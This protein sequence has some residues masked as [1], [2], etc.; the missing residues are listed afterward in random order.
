M[1]AQFLISRTHRSQLGKETNRT[2]PKTSLHGGGTM[3]ARHLQPHQEVAVRIALHRFFTHY[4]CPCPDL[5]E[6]RADCEAVAVVAVLTAD[7]ESRTEPLMS[8]MLS[9]GADCMP[10]GVASL[11]QVWEA[12]GEAER[13]RVLWLAR[14]AEN[15]LKRFWRQER[16]F[17]SRTEALEVTDEVGE[18]VE[19]EIEDQETLE[20]V[21]EQLYAKQLIVWLWSRLDKVEQAI[22]VGLSEGETQAEI[23]QV[24]GITQSA[25]AHRLRKIRAKAQAILEETGE[26]RG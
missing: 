1:P 20:A 10:C 7:D 16:R 11:Q 4:R 5:H 12:L 3:N 24:L 9:E 26:N 23:A 17:Y 6:W 8:E 21:L 22:M 19:R 18:W 25:V 15:A 13:R 14:Q 2:A